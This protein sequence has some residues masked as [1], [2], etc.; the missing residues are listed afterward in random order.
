MEEEL[1]KVRADIPVV[2][3]PVEGLEDL[4][5]DAEPDVLGVEAIA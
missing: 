1:T 4:C 2:D 3:V 5:L